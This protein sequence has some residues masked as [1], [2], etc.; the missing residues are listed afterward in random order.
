[1]RK[2]EFKKLTTTLI[3]LSMILMLL[4]II[5]IPTNATVNI[6]TEDELQN[7]LARREIDITIPTGTTVIIDNAIVI[8]TDVTLTV[9]G[10]INNNYGTI[11]NHGVINIDNDGLIINYYGSIYNFN[12]GLINNNGGEIDNCGFIINNGGSI[13]NSNGG[14]INNGD[15]IT[16]SNGGKINNNG[17]SINNGGIIYNDFSTINNENGVINSYG[18][19]CLGFQPLGGFTYAY[20]MVT[21]DPAN[22]DELTTDWI[23]EG[24]A[25]VRPEDPVREGYLF[26]GWF[27]G[28]AV[29]D[30]DTPIVDDVTLIAWWDVVVS[31]EFTV[32]FDSHGGSAVEPQTVVSGETAERPEDPVR[33]GYLF[34]GWFLGD[35]VFD[36]DTPIV[37]DVTLTAHWKEKD[38]KVPTVIRVTPSAL[39]TK[40]N[41]NMNDLTV[42]V[43][44][45]FSDGTTKTLSQ[46]FRINNNAANTYTVGSYTVYVG[47]TGNTK[48]SA[49][50]IVT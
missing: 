42:T 24:Y 27:L 4:P 9:K 31:V 44:E 28:D 5:T 14:K 22:D 37:D 38:D 32:S 23:L 16:N 18:G 10:T 21:F 12:S 11:I 13:T 34:L 41:G 7:A 39:V 48:I 15:W 30:F 25:V 35:A 17:G 6:T 33:E 47:T 50:Y 8:G 20:Y 46:T 36:F 2:T 19:R 49:C 26:L 3:V 43:V 40:L 1:M 45:L 29:F